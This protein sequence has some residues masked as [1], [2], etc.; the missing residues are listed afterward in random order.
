MNARRDV[1]RRSPR[2]RALSR[3]WALLMALTIGTMIAGRVSGA[4]ALGLPWVATLLAIT[5]VKAR[6]ILH[7]YLGLGTAP[8]HWRGGF[9]AILAILLLTILGIYAIHALGLVPASR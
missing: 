7:V 3:G 1:W 5:C 2:T 4:E 9:S 8:R 6:V